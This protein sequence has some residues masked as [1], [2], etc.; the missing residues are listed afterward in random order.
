MQMRFKIGGL[1][2]LTIFVMIVGCGEE[3]STTVTNDQPD[4]IFISRNT[5]DETLLIKSS[6]GQV[7]DLAFNVGGLFFTSR[8]CTDY[9]CNTPYLHHA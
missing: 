4:K 6:D 2:L 5:Q 8:D 3:N 1:V 7:Y 9:P